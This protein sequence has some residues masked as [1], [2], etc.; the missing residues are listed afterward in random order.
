MKDI[1]L[2][3]EKKK[4]WKFVR[5]QGQPYTA[6]MGFSE[7][8]DTKSVAVP[9]GTPSAATL[10]RKESLEKLAAEGVPTGTCCCSRCKMEYDGKLS[11]HL[12]ECPNR[13]TKGRNDGGRKRFP[14]KRRRTGKR[15]W[16]Q[17]NEGMD[18]DRLLGDVEKRRRELAKKLGREL[19]RN[20]WRI[21]VSG[22]AHAILTSKAQPVA[23]P[24]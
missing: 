16:R 7:F 1:K 15:L 18:K 19:E 22:Q 10:T 12:R 13:A 4:G 20:G 2:G 6:E 3:G 11:E 17:V 21:F 9:V 5:F 24:K 23:M 8:S 14:W